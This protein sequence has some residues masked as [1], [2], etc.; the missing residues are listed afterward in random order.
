MGAISILPVLA[1]ISIVLPV[2]GLT[3]LVSELI[4]IRKT[5]HENQLRGIEVQCLR[6]PNHISGKLEAFVPQRNLTL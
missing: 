4:R 1:V 6:V 3:Q 2:V 5:Y